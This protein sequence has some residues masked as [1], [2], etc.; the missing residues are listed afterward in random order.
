MINVG[1]ETGKKKTPTYQSMFISLTIFNKSSI[2]HFMKSRETH[3][4][5]QA[6]LKYSQLYYASAE[7]SSQTVKHL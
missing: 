3:P 7:P 6:F 4:S 1:Y 5:S 2:K